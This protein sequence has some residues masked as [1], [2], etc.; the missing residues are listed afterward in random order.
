MQFLRRSTRWIKLS[1]ESNFC[2]WELNAIYMHVDHVP[3]LENGSW[4]FR[5]RAPQIQTRKPRLRATS[6]IHTKLRLVQS[7][8]PSICFSHPEGKIDAQARPIPVPMANRLSS[9]CWLVGRAALI[10]DR[11]GSTVVR[12]Q[13]HRPVFV[14][15][16]K[17][18]VQPCNDS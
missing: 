11:H 5:L 14:I 12:Q 4:V 10:V 8:A 17:A 9:A 2:S 16:S 18:S 3:Y 15:G 1:L 6:T 7:A 13:K